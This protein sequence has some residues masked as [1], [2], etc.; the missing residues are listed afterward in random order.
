LFEEASAPA[1]TSVFASLVF[2]DVTGFTA[3][4]ERLAGRGKQGAEEITRVISAV[5]ETLLAEAFEQGGDLLKFGGDALMLLFT[6]EGH[7]RR[8]DE[9]ARRMQRVV[10]ETGEMRTMVGKV[11][12]GMSAGVASGPVHF[13]LVGDHHREILVLGPTV[14][15]ILGLESAA[16]SG[17][18]LADDFAA[19]AD[20]HAPSPPTATAQKIDPSAFLPEPLRSMALKGPL[21]A[22]HRPVAVAFG[23]LTGT[24]GLLAT[25]P[26]RAAQLFH[27]TVT[28]LEEL[29]EIHGVTFLG[30]DV[31]ADGFK[32]IFT[33]GAPL[34]LGDNEDRVLSLARAAVERRTVGG[35]RFGIATGPVFAGEIGAHSRRVYT[36]MGDT[37]NLAARLGEHALAGEVLTTQRT[38][39]RATR[40]FAVEQ[41]S[42]ITL[43]GKA[44]EITPLAVGETGDRHLHRSH[45][46]LVGRDQEMA[47]LA[48]ARERVRAG[49]GSLVEIA[50]PAGIGKSR[51]VAELVDSTVDLPVIQVHCE[52]YGRSVTFGVARRLLRSVLRIDSNAS[53]AEAA[54]RLRELAVGPA[55]GLQPWLPLV[56]GLLGADLEETP[57]TQAIDP[58]FRRERIHWAVTEL[59]IR[60]LDRP[61]VVLIEDSHWM[62]PASVELAAYLLRRTVGLPWLVCITRRRAEVGL[63][64]TEDMPGIRLDLTPLTAE[65]ARDLVTRATMEGPILPDEVAALVGRAAGNPFFLLGLTGQAGQD[66]LP[67]TVEAM[68]G[69][70]ID[71]LFP[72]ER[73]AL[74]SLAVLGPRFEG[75]IV[76]AVLGQELASS[77][78]ALLRAELGDFVEPAGPGAYQF[79]H[80]L[81]QEAAYAG[82]PYATR[83][84]LH[85]SVVKALEGT[86]DGSSEA[87]LLSLHCERAGLWARAW[88][89]AVTAGR[90]A[91]E[92]HAP[93]DAVE[94]YRRA[95]RVAG[96]IR[97]IERSEL[98]EAAQRLGDLSDLTGRYE[99]AANAYRRARRNLD[100]PAKDARLM[101]K[102]GLMAERTGRYRTA[103][104][105]LGR[106]YDRATSDEEALTEIEVGFAGVRFR[107]DRYR[108]ALDWCDL[109]IRR[110]DALGLQRELAHAYY[111]RG[112]ARSLLDHQAHSDDHLKALA[113]YRD[114]DDIVGQANVYNNLGL[115]YYYQG[116]WS[117]AA[118]YHRQSEELRQRA[119]DVTGSAASAFNR[120]LILYDQ[121][122][123]S[124]AELAFEHVRQVG[125][126]AKSP[127]LEGAAACYLGAICARQGDHARADE[128]FEASLSRLES[129]AAA[130]FTN[131]VKLK[132]AE[133]HVIAGRLEE[134]EKAALAGIEATQGRDGME[135]SL[136]GFLRVAAAA[137]F[138]FGEHAAS[139]DLLHRALA[140]ARAS[141]LEYEEALLLE[142][143]IASGGASQADLDRRDRI[144][145]DLGVI[146]VPLK[147]S[148]L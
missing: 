37:V 58:K 56:G 74:R 35:L 29:A 38:L 14:T 63:W 95:L 23:K 79:R 53:P 102:L 3:L 78:D 77:F 40:A 64:L 124:E 28:M 22:E 147:F 19:D 61:T 34:A 69:A 114:L 27:Q 108:D 18:I 47:I 93:R 83:R 1:H 97:S 100:S 4:S 145:N 86:G 89:Y 146:Q 85:A 104:H 49:Q 81:Y 135:A 84:R 41:R 107:Q 24:D 119:G 141:Q 122:R 48:E 68:A 113:I 140:L 6:G 134:A 80:A 94:F 62:D 2:T 110:A 132:Q 126:A 137:R 46:P 116:R 106:A 103:L 142:G 13:L 139:I 117:Q 43:K 65:A 73:S 98:V 109:A 131:D 51:L 30:T 52:E 21:P 138:G 50:G 8:A 39:E 71:R 118:E 60:L 70:E 144:L 111:L 20:V 67:E 54:S 75:Q 101:L 42:K 7:R 25:D 87:G 125:R 31:A 55:K 12:L 129:T 127:L 90:R 121:G 88:Q 115:E 57:Q 96:R 128:W 10:K 59:L 136:V 11:A 92:L 112:H 32:V 123:L 143:F 45:L 9:A 130:F 44:K 148:G 99:E 33:A 91:A 5:F 16:R 72:G 15:R 76:A 120:A 82:L 36:V 133:A 105:W 26:A 66:E 17:E